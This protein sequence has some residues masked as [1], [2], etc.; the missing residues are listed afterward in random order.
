MLCILVCNMYNNNT[1]WIISICELRSM[2]IAKTKLEDAKAAIKSRK[3]KKNRSNGQKNRSNGQKNKDQRTNN[4]PQNTTR[5]NTYRETRTPLKHIVF[6]VKSEM[7]SEFN[8]YWTQVLWKGKQF[9]FDWWHPSCFFLF[10][11]IIGANCHF[12]SLSVNCYYLYRN[13]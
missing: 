11:W 2:V 10:S 3:S 5:K 1:I 7:Q 4:V 9:L 12:P 6:I 13:Y 8:N